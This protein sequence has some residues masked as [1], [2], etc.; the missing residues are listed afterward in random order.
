MRGPG[1][2]CMRMRQGTPEKCVVIG[3][4]TVYSL[5][6]VHRTARHAEP[7]NDHYGNATNR[8][9]D[10]SACARSVYQAHSPPLEGPGYEATL[11]TGRSG[12]RL[13]GQC[14]C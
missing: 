14:D 12:A 10:S 5:F 7:A 11:F 4:S 2:H 13:L 6:I 8:Y 9:G 1:T 3:Y